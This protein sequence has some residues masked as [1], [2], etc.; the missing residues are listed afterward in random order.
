MANHDFQDPT[1]KAIE[2]R[3]S[4]AKELTQQS[5]SLVSQLAAFKGKFDTL[6]IAS[7]P[8]Q[9]AHLDTVFQSFKQDAK[10]AL[11]L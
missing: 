10:A 4:Y 9:Q 11:G 3:R 7:T 8:E 1:E 5:G 6:Y 2:N